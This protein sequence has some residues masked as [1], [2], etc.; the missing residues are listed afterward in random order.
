MIT[1]LM[2]RHGARGQK[3]LL[4]TTARRLDSRRGREKLK[5]TLP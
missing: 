4:V 3:Q 1:D 5:E 2:D